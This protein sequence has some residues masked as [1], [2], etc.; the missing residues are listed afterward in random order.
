MALPPNQLTEDDKKKIV[1]KLKEK[2]VRTTCP[3]CNNNKFVLADGYFSHPI[4]GNIQS[5]LVIGGPAIPTIAIICTNCGFTSEH[6]LG[7]LGLLPIKEGD[8]K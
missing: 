7:A 5:G 1:D 8:S 2:G 4:Q 3:M 6:A